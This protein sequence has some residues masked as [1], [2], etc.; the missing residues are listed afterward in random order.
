MM[1]C[2]HLGKCMG[3]NLH[4]W[5]KITPNHTILAKLHIYGLLTKI[6]QYIFC[7]FGPK[8]CFF[9]TFWQKSHFSEAK[10]HFI[11]IVPSTFSYALSIATL[12]SSKSDHIHCILTI[13]RGYYYWKPAKITAQLKISLWTLMFFRIK[14]CSPHQKHQK[15]KA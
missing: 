13:N 5:S 6:A 9:D 4:F 14:W 10:L 2:R 3:A 11:P 7:T 1:A 12:Q 15:L 8:L